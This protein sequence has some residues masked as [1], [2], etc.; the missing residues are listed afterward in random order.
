[1]GREF[2]KKQLKEI[3]Y[4]FLIYCGYEHQVLPS[5]NS[6]SKTEANE[7]EIL[8]TKIVLHSF[9]IIILVVV[10]VVAVIAAVAVKCDI[11]IIGI[12]KGQLIS[13]II[14]TAS[15][16]NRTQHVTITIT[17]AVSASSFMS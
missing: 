1:M 17:A 16:H 7:S 14:I 10:I 5:K 13:W 11:S 15:H 3:G 9:I 2:A 8:S 6:I 4:G 12:T